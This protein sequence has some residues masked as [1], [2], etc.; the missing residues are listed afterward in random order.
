MTCGSALLY[1]VCVA[2][3]FA[4][5]TPTHYGNDLCTLTPPT[6]NEGSSTN[7]RAIFKSNTTI[8]S[9]FTPNFS[10]TP[11]K[12]PP[13]RKS[14]SGANH[15]TYDCVPSPPTDDAIS[16]NYSTPLPREPSLLPSN[17]H[18]LESGLLLLLNFTALLTSPD[19]STPD[20]VNPLLSPGQFNPLVSE[21]IHSDR[22]C[23]VTSSATNQIAPI[24]AS[25]EKD[26]SNLSMNYEYF[27]P[28]T[29]EYKRNKVSAE[30]IGSE[31]Q[32]YLAETVQRN[33]D[34]TKNEQFSPHA[35]YRQ[36]SP[37]VVMETLPLVTVPL[38]WDYNVPLKIEEKNNFTV[39]R[40]LGM[41]AHS[42]LAW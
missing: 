40:V 13:L 12:I 33:F 36:Q 18:H 6:N 34:F 2:T 5:T 31:E 8:S 25:F 15:E 29:P 37:V 19:L 26:Q 35:K 9:E 14:A 22:P 30:N 24:A 32:F 42:V 41:L 7:A 1:L 28:L 20:T 16:Y 3:L 27:N 23:N 38:H 11:P 17:S 39:I 21:L 10:N 4:S